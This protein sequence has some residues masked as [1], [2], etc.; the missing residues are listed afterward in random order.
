MLC[1]SL[2]AAAVATPAASKNDPTA[3]L[4]IYSGSQVSADY[5]GSG[6]LTLRKLLCLASETGSFRL[7]V[8]M[9]SGAI[10]EITANGASLVV[11][12]PNGELQT[13]PLTDSEMIFQGSN[14]PKDKRCIQGPN[15]EM[16][17]VLPEA[18]LTAAPAGS[19]FKALQ[20]TVEP[21]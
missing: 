17:L 16:S 6:P 11:K 20:M 14:L 7:R 2:L 9:G 15:A 12:L 21:V 19:Y 5:Y 13:R 18:A 4:K 3:T 10:D 8:Q 1:C